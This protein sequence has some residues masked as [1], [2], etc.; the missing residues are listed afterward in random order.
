MLCMHHVIPIRYVYPSG[1][2]YSWLL[3][4]DHR[5]NRTTKLCFD[6]YLTPRYMTV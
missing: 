2:F 6:T 3:A 5:G 1:G 4:P